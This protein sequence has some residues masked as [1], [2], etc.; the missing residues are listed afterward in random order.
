[1]TIE[2]HKHPAP[3]TVKFGLVD[4]GGILSGPLGGAD[5]RLN[6]AGNRWWIE[7]HMPPMMA[8]VATKYISRLTRGKSERARIEWFLGDFNPGNPGNPILSVD[9]EQGTTIS[10]SGFNP[11]YPIREGQFFSIEGGDGKHFIYQQA[12]DKDVVVGAD[13]SVS[14]KIYPPLRRRTGAGHKCHFAKPMIEGY[15]HGNG[16]Q[17]DMAVDHSMG[18]SFMIK[19]DE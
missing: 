5:T 2:L 16:Q 15:V 19:E 14:L 12:E 6:R 3:A 8:T 13:G 11:H 7:C 10:L 1:M 9:G 18:F 4:Y 17:W